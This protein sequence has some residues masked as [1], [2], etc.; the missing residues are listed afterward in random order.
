MKIVCKNCNHTFEG[1]YCNYCGQ[2]AA[3]S[4]INKHFLLHDI[5]MGF[6]SFDRGILFTIRELITRPGLAIKDFLEG[7]RVRYYKPI[8]FL[9]L[10]VGIYSFIFLF[11]D[12]DVTRLSAYKDT[13]DISYKATEWIT[14][15]FAVVS[16]ML[17]PVFSLSTFLAFR[18][19]G[20]NYMEHIVINS[21]LLGMTTLIAIVYSPIILLIPK[22]YQW[23]TSSSLNIIISS[24]Y[25]FWAYYQIFSN[26]KPRKRVLKICLVLV[27]LLLIMLLIVIPILSLIMLLFFGV[28]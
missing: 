13:G 7:K 18:R 4:T 15:H 9:L 26:L 14:N 24:S 11:F 21:Y 20:Y 16:L 8:S 12:I 22:E 25:K 17:L 10:F 2:A 6:L 28:R 23:A 5:Q 27:Y 3:T 19:Y 1:N